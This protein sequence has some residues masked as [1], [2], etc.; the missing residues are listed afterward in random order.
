MWGVVFL[1]FSGGLVSVDRGSVVLRFYGFF[2]GSLMIT[3]TATSTATVTATATAE[4]LFEA[5]RVY[6]S[7]TATTTAT[8]TTT[9]TTSVTAERLFGSTAVL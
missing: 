5:L 1:L 9:T 2:C 6:G 3:T 8:S 4:R 7:S